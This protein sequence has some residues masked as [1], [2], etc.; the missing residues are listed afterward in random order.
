MAR[1]VGLVVGGMFSATYGC[2]EEMDGRISPLRLPIA[3]SGVHAR[4]GRNGM[5]SD[6][7]TRRRTRTVS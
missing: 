1:G 6:D 2:Q 7:D 4:S 3:S 5:A